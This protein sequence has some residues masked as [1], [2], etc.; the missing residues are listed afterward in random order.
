[1]RR[2]EIHEATDWEAEAREIENGSEATVL[3]IRLE[4]ETYRIEDPKTGEAVNVA[5][6]ERVLILMDDPFCLTA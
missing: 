6:G 4:G 2:V 3:E 5:T 1:M